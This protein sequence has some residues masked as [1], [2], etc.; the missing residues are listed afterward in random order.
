MSIKPAAAQSAVDDPLERRVSIFGRVHL[1]VEV[2][3]V[4][5]KGRIVPPGERGELAPAAIASSNWNESER[6]IEVSDNAAGMHTGN[7]ASH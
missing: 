5:F 4:D 2:E 6:P 1:H 3:V 7:V